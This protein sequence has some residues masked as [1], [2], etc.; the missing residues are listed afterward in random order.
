[1]W[2]FAVMGFQSYYLFFYFVV[3]SFIGW[4]METCYATFLNRRFINRGFLNGPFC[5]VYGFG[6]IT[7]VIFL[8]PLKNDAFLLFAGGAIL[9][10][11]LE[12]IT[13]FILEKSFH[14]KWWDYSD[15]PHN[16]HGRICLRFSVLWGILSVVLLSTLHPCINFII[17]LMPARSGIIAARTLMAYLAVDLILTVSSTLHLNARLKNISLISNE[18]KSRLEYLKTSSLPQKSEELQRKLYELKSRYEELLNKKVFFHTR[19]LD[20]FPGI[21]SIRFD[22]NLKELKSRLGS[23]RSKAGGKKQ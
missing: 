7:I 8:T 3:Y 10:S 18:I 17:S 15:K 2:N 14:T 9:T 12:Y 6:A 4:I 5:P 20:A 21:R 13:G 1:M 23:F 19:L 11:V 22:A 16:L